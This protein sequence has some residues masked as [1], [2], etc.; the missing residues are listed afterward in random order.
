MGR[1]FQ[2]VRGNGREGL[3]FQIGWQGGGIIE[4][5]TLGQRLEGGEGLSWT[6]F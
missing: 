3:W 1:C 2:D 6:E 5:I 4:K